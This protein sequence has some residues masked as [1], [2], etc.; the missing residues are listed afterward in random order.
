MTA[1]PLA[2]W[3]DDD[4]SPDPLAAWVQSDRMPAIEATKRP[5]ID[6]LRSVSAVDIAVSGSLLVVVYQTAQS[7]SSGSNAGAV[8]VEVQDISTG[9]VLMPA[10]VVASTG[11][12][13]AY[14]RVLVSGTKAYVVYSAAGE[15]DY[16]IVDLTTLL[17]GT[18]GSLVTNA[19]A[20][21]PTFFDVVIG[22]PTAGVPTLYLAYELDAGTDRCRVKSFTVSTL[23]A[24][25]SS[26]VSG[27][28]ILAVSL[29]FGA[30]AQRVTLM[31]ATSSTTN[32][33]SFATNLGSITAGPTVLYAGASVYVFAVEDDAT[34]LL[35]GW[36]GND[37]GA[38]LT[39][40]ERL[41]S[42]LYPVATHAL[43]ANT[44]RIT[45]G[46][47]YTSTPWRLDGRWYLQAVTFPHPYSGSSTDPIAQKSTVILHVDTA[48]T[49]ISG[50]SKTL[51]PHMH[52]ATIEN[53]TGSYALHGFN[54]K[55]VVGP[56]GDVYV[57]SV[58]RDREPANIAT[59][60]P[61]GFDLCRLSISGADVLRAAQLGASALLAGGA[62]AWFDGWLARPYGF[63]AAPQIISVTAAAGG[64]IVAGTYSYIATYAW[65]DMNGVLHRSMPSFPKSGTTATTNLKLTVKV[66]TSSLSHKQRDVL[67]TA[68][69][70]GPVMIELWRTVI[71]GAGPHYRITHEPGTNV[72]FSDPT[73]GDVS[74]TDAGSDASITG[75]APAVTLASQP[76]LYTDL[77]EL[78]NIP[79]P[80]LVSVA[81]H[82]GRLVGIGPDLRTV[83]MSKDSRLDPTLAPGFNEALTLAFSS[84]KNALASLDEKLVV[85]GENTIDVVFGDGPGDDGGNN[86]WDV[87]AVQTDVGCVNPRSVAVCPMGSVFESPRGIELLSRDLTVSWIG[88]AIDDTLTTYPTITSAVLVAEQSEVRFTCDNGST[89][90][91]LAWDYRYKIW[92]VRKYNDAADTT[93]ASVR[94]VDAAL[95]DGVYTLLT[96]GGQ[97][98]RETA[99]HKLDNGTAFVAQDIILAP[100]SPEPGKA[101]WGNGNLGWY[102]VKD[103]TLMGTSVTPHDLSISFASDYAASYSQTETFL[104]GSDVTA[105]GPLEK[106][107]ATLAQQ[108]CQAVQIRIQATTPTNPGTY[109]IGTGDGLIL[110]AL[111]LRVGVKEGPAKVG[112]GQEK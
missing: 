67:S 18:G 7:A 56:T 89:G 83:W 44:D 104:A 1:E 6:S 29:L 66:S 62:P 27:T 108:K 52:A 40:A 25:A 76:Q 4:K 75:A 100:I 84:D 71:G 41:T 78:E 88:D 49:N 107:R 22:T 80:S 106:C 28:G 72:L 21:T 91:V 85:Y 86:T 63:A 46:I 99:A 15:V 9:A 13:N 50:V 51:S 74:L 64:A 70:S 59:P 17:F 98:Y 5:L 65:R 58:Y 19:K 16:R 26:D 45:Y 53:Q 34:N 87:H 93:T 82:R 12:A 97:V 23:A 101:G 57:P 68:S 20:A 8:F 3:V 11:S 105:P 112:I 90:I 73:A 33:A 42:G 81:T 36:Q 77:G 24:V 31:V 102:R 30:L 38:T 96:A 61:T 94:F 79:P 2:A 55:A 32:V 14:P 103:C 95:I 111:A 109:P 48:P 110:E 10:R 35:L 43:V 69:A 39:D 47:T 60:V 37:S 92:F 54:V